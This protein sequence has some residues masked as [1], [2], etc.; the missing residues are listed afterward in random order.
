M[1]EHS[2]KKSREIAKSNN[3]IKQRLWFEV[4]KI[5]ILVPK[6][7]AITVTRI[8]QTFLGIVKIVFLAKTCIRDCQNCHSELSKI[9]NRSC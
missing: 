9:A 7:I 3:I 2:N 1:L 8:G 4:L 6:F 5:I